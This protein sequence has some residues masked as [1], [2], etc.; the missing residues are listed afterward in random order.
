MLTS[1]L[2]SASRVFICEISRMRPA[3]MLYSQF[4]PQSIKTGIFHQ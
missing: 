1:R 4:Y 3:A 2:I